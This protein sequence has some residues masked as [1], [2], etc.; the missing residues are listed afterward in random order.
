[1]WLFNL[2]MSARFTRHDVIA[3]DTPNELARSVTNVA[4]NK[5]LAKVVTAE[6]AESAE[7]SFIKLPT[8]RS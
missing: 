6:D 5:Q 3:S 2:C 4:S 8:P 7:E 1:M